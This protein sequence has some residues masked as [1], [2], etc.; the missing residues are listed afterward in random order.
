MGGTYIGVLKYKTTMNDV[1]RSSSF[2]CHIAD[3]NVAPGFHVRKM[4]RGRAGGLTVARRVVVLP[5]RCSVLTL[6]LSEVG[7]DERDAV[8]TYSGVLHYTPMN[9]NCHSSF[10]CHVA[11]SDVAPGFRV[12]DE[13]G[14]DVAHFSS[15]HRRL[16]STFV[17]C[18]IAVGDLAPA[19]RVRK[20]AREGR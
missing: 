19:P 7:W 6:C 17:R 12:T 9:D 5:H 14:V 18:H 10:G 11:V 3:G 4:S 13:Q 15:P 8:G 2:G 1:H 20:G 16:W